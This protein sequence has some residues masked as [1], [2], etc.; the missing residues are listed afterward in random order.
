MALFSRKSATPPPAGPSVGGN[1]GDLFDEFAGNQQQRRYTAEIGEVTL[2][3]DTSNRELVGVISVEPASV[4]YADAVQIKARDDDEL[5]AQLAKL[6]GLFAG[7]T[8]LPG[9]MRLT[10]VAAPLRYST[11]L[12]GFSKDELTK[13]TLAAVAAGAAPSVSAPAPATP[14]PSPPAAPEPPPPVV[15]APVAQPRTPEP[16]VDFDLYA[17]GDTLFFSQIAPMAR[18]AIAL[19]W[20]NE[21][22]ARHGEAD[23]LAG[24]SS[25]ILKEFGDWQTRVDDVISGR[26]TILLRGDRATDSMLCVVLDLNAVTVVECSGS[27]VGRV[28]G[29]L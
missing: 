11:K 27:A 5:T 21:I 26:K 29:L 20:S 15:A 7:L 22:L 12:Q 19:T 18:A 10:S 6:G 3:C 17:A 13:A 9:K 8:G 24:L 28:I 14:E 23:D 16:E 4:A 1:I 25:A 2:V